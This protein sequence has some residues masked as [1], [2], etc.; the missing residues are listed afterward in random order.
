MIDEMIFPQMLQRSF[1]GAW[2][3]PGR[4]DVVAWQT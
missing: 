2:E 4:D 3:D 1:V